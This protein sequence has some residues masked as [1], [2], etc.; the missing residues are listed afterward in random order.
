MRQRAPALT[1]KALN[2]TAQRLYTAAI[3]LQAAAGLGL[4]NRVYFP[5]LPQIETGQLVGL[6][7]LSAFAGP[8]GN[9]GNI[10]QSAPIPIGYANVSVFNYLTSLMVSLVNKG[11]EVIFDRIPYASLFPINGKVKRYNAVNLDS[12][13]CFFTFP[14]GTIIS[15]N[16]NANLGFY[17][18]YQPQ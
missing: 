2:P 3:P 16:I 4:G 13:N 9:A 10:S 18:N 17:M 8:A 6:V 5:H 15:G 12:R 14:A 11:G 1:V 7:A